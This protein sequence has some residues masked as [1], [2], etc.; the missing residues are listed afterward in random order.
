MLKYESEIWVCSN[1]FLEESF[2]Y[3]IYFLYS[4]LYGIKKP[5][6]DCEKLLE[7]LFELKIFV[8]EIEFLKEFSNYN[9]N[10]FARLSFLSYFKKSEKSKRWTSFGIFYENLIARRLTDVSLNGFLILP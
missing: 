10:A 1:T 9:S 6:Y 5:D 8:T 7:L 2:F 3:D 4:L